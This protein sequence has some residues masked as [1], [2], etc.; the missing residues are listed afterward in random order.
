[1]APALLGVHSRGT[2]PQCGATAIIPWTEVWRGLRN[3]PVQAICTS[4]HHVFAAGNPGSGKFQGDR[5]LANKLLHP[6]RW[7][8]VA[9]RVPHDPSVIYVERIVGLPN[10]QVIIRDGS[11]WI[12]GKQQMP[13]LS[14]GHLKYVTTVPGGDGMRAEWGTERHPAQLGPDEY[15]VLGDFSESSYDSRFWREGAPGHH[16]YAVPASNIVGVVT[17]IY[18]PISRWRSFR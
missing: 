8:I 17:H 18:W 2:C 9:L 11:V 13:S 16:P 4:D 6:R 3:F 12:D 14:C 1:M 10:E 5:I 7:D 15:F